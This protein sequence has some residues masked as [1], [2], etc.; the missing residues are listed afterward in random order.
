[1]RVLNVL[2]WAWWFCLRGRAQ[3]V[4]ALE[5][6]VARQSHDL[7]KVS[8]LYCSPNSQW[9][10]RSGTSTAGNR[11]APTRFCGNHFTP[12]L[13][14]C[15]MPHTPPKYHPRDLPCVSEKVRNIQR[16]P[17]MSKVG[18]WFKL[19]RNLLLELSPKTTKTTKILTKATSF[20]NCKEVPQSRFPKRSTHGIQICLR[21]IVR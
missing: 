4:T 1:M 7:V 14:P 5:R 6:E 10:W 20:K 13:F 11:N 18:N 19:K 12:R 15:L 3:I 2:K 9:R 17:Q 16:S 8:V 21:T